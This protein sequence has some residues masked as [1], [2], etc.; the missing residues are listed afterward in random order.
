MELLAN[1]RQIYM[2]IDNCAMCVG[3]KGFYLNSK[4]TSDP[5]RKNHSKVSQYRMAFDTPRI[6]KTET[7]KLK[8]LISASFKPL[9]LTIPIGDGFHELFPVGHCHL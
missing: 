9:S 8:N 5:S 4:E 6:T 1:S 2:A 3:G 7:S